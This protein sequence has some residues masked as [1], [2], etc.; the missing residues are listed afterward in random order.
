MKLEICEFNRW[1]QRKTHDF[2]NIPFTEGDEENLFCLC[3]DEERLQSRKVPLRLLEGEKCRF[4][5]VIDRYRDGEMSF[6]ELISRLSDND[7]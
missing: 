7:Y 6:D 2:P 3:Y 4:K 5:A 1:G